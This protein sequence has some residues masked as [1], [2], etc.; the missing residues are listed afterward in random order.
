M[1]I[2][3]VRFSNLFLPKEFANVKAYLFCML[4]LI[5]DEF[6]VP[7]VLLC[8]KDSRLFTKVSG[9]G[10]CCYET[11]LSKVKLNYLTRSTVSE[12]HKNFILHFH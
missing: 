6:L 12:K 2:L 9:R 3:I 10:I 5:P 11:M 8:L 7:Y 1:S 4:Q